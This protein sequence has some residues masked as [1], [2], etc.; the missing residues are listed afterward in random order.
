MLCLCL[1]GQQGVQRR[2]EVCLC[3]NSCQ[4]VARARICFKCAH[5]MCERRYSRED[6]SGEL[7]F[8]FH[9]GGL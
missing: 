8:V 4:D 9:Q 1:L 7:V 5:C 3:V 2:E 6:R